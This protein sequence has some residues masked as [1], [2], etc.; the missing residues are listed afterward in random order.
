MGTH[1]IFESDFDCLTDEP[2]M[3]EKLLRRILP[4]DKFTTLCEVLFWFNPQKS[5]IYL[6]ATSVAFHLVYFA[7]SNGL[8]YVVCHFLLFKLWYPILTQRIWPM[9]CMPEMAMF[10]EWTTL[11]PR[12]PDY[13]IS[14]DLISNFIDQKCAILAQVKAN[15]HHSCVFVTCSTLIAIVGIGLG[16]RVPGVYLFYASLFTLISVPMIF[17]EPFLRRVKHIERAKEVRVVVVDEPEPMRVESET[18]S[19]VIEP[20]TESESSDEECMRFKKSD[21]PNPE[22]TWMEDFS[23]NVTLTIDHV[24]S[25]VKSQIE[26]AI[27][28]RIE[29]LQPA[30]K[31]KQQSS[32]DD[33]SD[34][35]VV[36][37]PDDE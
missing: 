30:N 29:R 32:S 21:D 7:C 36:D 4:E 6:S 34:F 10:A 9:I 26:E 20:Y 35:V 23:Y 8:V 3:S 22:P 24:S 25:S 12:M 13:S 5:L 18:E 14:I 2:Q 1:P 27:S 33:N 17:S 31:T 19:D 15:R 37:T 16:Q 11:D 28:S